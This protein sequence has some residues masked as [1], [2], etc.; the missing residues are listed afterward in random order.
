MDWGCILEKSK[1]AKKEEEQGPLLGK[2][3]KC[4]RSGKAKLVV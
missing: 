2:K 4:R 1:R 3:K